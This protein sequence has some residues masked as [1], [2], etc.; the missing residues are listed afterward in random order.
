VGIE[1]QARQ[2]DRCSHEV[3]V[4]LAAFARLRR[5][6][7]KAVGVVGGTDGGLIVNGAVFDANVLTVATGIEEHNGYARSFI[8]ARKTSG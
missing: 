2:I 5:A 4:E 6:R 3:A 7:V 8:E 1:A